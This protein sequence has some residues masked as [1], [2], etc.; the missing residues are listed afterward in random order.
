MAVYCYVYKDIVKCLIGMPFQSNRAICEFNRSSSG[1]A[2]RESPSSGTILQILWKLWSWPKEMCNFLYS[3][4]Q[5][6]ARW[7]GGIGSVKLGQAWPVWCR[8]LLPPPLC[9]AAADCICPPGCHG[10]S[11]G[12]LYQHQCKQ[13]NVHLHCQTPLCF[14]APRLPCTTSQSDHGNL[15]FFPKVREE[16]CSLPLT[17]PFL[18]DALAIGNTSTKENV[19][20]FLQ[21]LISRLY[22]S[23]SKCWC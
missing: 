8:R 22:I 16:V 3:M 20:S 10:A 9:A 5:A 17:F 15:G 12:H 21:F 11:R 1:T 4:S 18:E 2:C 14:H 19:G 6:K 7:P 23:H 13:T